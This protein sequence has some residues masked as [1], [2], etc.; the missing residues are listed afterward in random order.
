M[1]HKQFSFLCI[2]S[3]ALTGCA[4]QRVF[5]QDW[6]VSYN[7]TWGAPE[8]TMPVVI[9]YHS[10]NGTLNQT[11]SVYTSSLFGQKCK[12]LGDVQWILE[13][14][15]GE[16][17][18]PAEKSILQ[19]N[20]MIGLDK[21]MITEA[22]KRGANYIHYRERSLH[23]MYCARVKQSIFAYEGSAS[24]FHCTDAPAYAVGC[25]DLRALLISSR[26]GKDIDFMYTEH[27]S[28]DSS[29]YF[30]YTND[31]SKFISARY[32]LAWVDILEA[33]EKKL[34]NVNDCRKGIP[35]SVL[36]YWVDNGTWCGP[37]T[38]K[39]KPKGMLDYSGRC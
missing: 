10:K 9:P 22:A 2:L 11:Y 16:S 21:S 7:G 19:Y 29:I 39:G 15:Y 36:R 38:N 28:Q 17:I 23:S 24:L 3:F 5:Y 30:S 6:L 13:L 20:D 26:P 27:I 35:A 8:N 1:M 33:C 37:V 14:S 12:S 34:G 31:H 18:N 32:P 4:T 25:N